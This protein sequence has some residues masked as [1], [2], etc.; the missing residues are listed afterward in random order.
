MK[1]MLNDKQMKKIKKAPYRSL[2]YLEKYL[3]SGTS[4]MTWNKWNKWTFFHLFH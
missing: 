3:F 2:F 1:S 4:E